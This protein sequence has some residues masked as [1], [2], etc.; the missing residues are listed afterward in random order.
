MSIYDEYGLELESENYGADPELNPHKKSKV[1]VK[2]KGG[3]LGKV[4]SLLLGIVIGAG[5]VV[6]GVAGVGYYAVSTPVKDVMGTVGNL[7]GTNINYTEYISEEYAKGTVIDL[8]GE[9]VKIAQNF[10]G[11][12]GCLNDLVKISPFVG[13]AFDPLFKILQGYG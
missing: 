9:T 2:K 7:T 13:T 8:V 1:I 3:F 4:I 12:K 5:G 6:G 10:A 11:G